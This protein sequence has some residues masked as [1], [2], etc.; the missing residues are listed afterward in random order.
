VGIAYPLA[1]RIAKDVASALGD[2][3][4]QYGGMGRNGAQHLQGVHDAELDQSTTRLDFPHDGVTNLLV[5]RVV[6]DH[7]DVAN[8]AVVGAVLNVFRA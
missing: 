5:D 7:G 2:R 1:S 8:R 3:D 4:D 6:A